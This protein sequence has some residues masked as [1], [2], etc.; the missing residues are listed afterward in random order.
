[1][2][3]FTTEDMIRFLY[4]ELQQEAADEFNEA[5]AKDWNLKERFKALQE[6]MTGLEGVQFSPSNKVLDSIM[7]YAEDKSLTKSH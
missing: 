7:H 4:N 3:N 6:A 2:T 1:M 5:L